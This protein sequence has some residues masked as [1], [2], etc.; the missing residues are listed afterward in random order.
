MYYILVEF[1]HSS[2][3]ANLHRQA[4]SLLEDSYNQRSLNLFSSTCNYFDT[5]GILL[6]N[7]MLFDNP[8]TSVPS[9]ITALASQYMSLGPLSDNILPSRPHRLAHTAISDNYIHSFAP[10]IDSDMDGLFHDNMFVHNLLP[11]VSR[12]SGPPAA[13]LTSMSLTTASSTVQPS[14]DNDVDFNSDKE[15]S[16]Q[17]RKNS[18]S[19][20]R[21][22][23]LTASQKH[24]RKNRLRIQKRSNKSESLDN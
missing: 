12:L 14:D 4:L 17:V 2:D 24:S 23:Y 18:K 9:S 6:D 22:S 21:R 11:H 8:S 5:D 20:H 1:P 16:T 7:S 10:Q 13:L 15:V 3:S 19:K